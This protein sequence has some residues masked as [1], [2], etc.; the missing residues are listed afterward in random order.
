VECFPNG[1]NAARAA[2]CVENNIAQYP[3]WRI[4][5]TWY[6]EILSPE[7]LAAMT[8]YRPPPGVKP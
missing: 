7:R 2:V 5:G 6:G 4:G 8:N 1:Q 3:T